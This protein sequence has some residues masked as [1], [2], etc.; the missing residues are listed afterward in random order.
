[1]KLITGCLE[2]LIDLGPSSIEECLSV[3]SIISK[4]LRNYRRENIFEELLKKYLLDNNKYIRVWGKINPDL[5]EDTLFEE[6]IRM[7]LVLQKMK[8]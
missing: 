6:T 4:T 5:V 8:F 1:M 3:K 2:N 7:R